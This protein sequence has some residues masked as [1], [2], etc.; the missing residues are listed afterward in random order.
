MVQ[1]GISETD[2]KPPIGAVVLI[3]AASL[4]YQLVLMK[5]FSIIHWHHFAYMIISLA[6]LGVGVSG[7]LIM[8]LQKRLL[9]YFHSLFFGN[10]LLFGLS[11]LICFLLAQQIPFNT[12]EILWDPA[13]WSYLFGIYLLLFLPFLF[14]ANCILLTLSRFQ[15]E[16]PRIYAFNLFGAGLGMLAT[17]LIMFIVPPMQALRFIALTGLSAALLCCIQFGIRARFE[18]FRLIITLVVT[19]ALT[20]IFLPQQW[21]TLNINPYK[22]LS[23]TLRIPGTQVISHFSSPLALLTVVKSPDV[24]LRSVPG[25]SLMS[26]KEPLPQLGVFTDADALSPINH[27]QGKRESL[28]YLDYLTSALPY[29]LREVSADN[30][31]VIILGTGGGTHILQA[32]YHRANRIAAIELN[33]QM[34]GLLQDQ[35]ADYAGWSH[36][37]EVKLHVGEARGHLNSAKQRFDLIQMPP[38][39]SSVASGAG[40]HALMENY[41][42]TTEALALFWDRLTADGLLSITSWTKLPPRDSLKLIA[43]ARQALSTRGI[44]DAGQHLAAIRG[45][46]TSTLLI[47][48]QPFETSELQQIREFSRQRGFDLVYLPDMRREEA[49][50]Y[51]LLQ[52]PYFFDGAVALLG[53][54]NQ[55]H[56]DRYKFNITPATDD[57]PYFYQFFKWRS[58]LELWS[59]K[60]QSGIALLEWG[61]PLLIVTLIQALIASLAL[62]LAP[63]ALV[64][65]GQR[66]FRPSGRQLWQLIWYF[67]A[68]GFAFMFVEIAFIHKFTLFLSHPLYSMAAVVAGFLV[69]AGSGSLWA[70]NCLKRKAFTANQLI[71]A[72]IL[73]IGA[74]NL[75]YLAILPG[76][77]QQLADGLPLFKTLVTLALLA[78]LAFC[79]GIPFPGGLTRV[80]S[81][82]PGWIPWAWCINGCASVVGAI[83]ATVLSIHYGFNMVILM[84]VLLY[85]SIASIKP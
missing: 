67:L 50:R 57:R 68:I 28:D 19:L 15:Q 43:T 69:F 10:A 7:S 39:G 48:K 8:P 9:P 31:S 77:F 20:T 81:R 1:T 47:N 17:I 6:L 18:Y 21:Q 70:G 76:I 56:T 80:S 23:N 59:L 12:L 49:N 40:L 63:L 60:G 24:P 3:S 25:V 37:P 66:E 44:E 27:Y 84:A 65:R 72:S 11:T 2:S 33:P 55:V 61:Y 58:L 45:W 4:G 14:A 30:A 54:R 64:F 53:D 78:P 22:E 34:A 52:E 82:L 83:A 35:F 85:V 41:L 75:L 32:H 46:K 13:Q 71:L 42:Y 5:L 62:I 16:V 29:H 79:M 26:G 36:L 73:A 74:I 51:N 38:M